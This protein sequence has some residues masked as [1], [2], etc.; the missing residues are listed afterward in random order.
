MDLVPS[1][2]Y[3]LPEISSVGLTER[4]LLA[5]Q[6]PYEVG[7]TNFKSLA[8]AQMT[9]Q[10]IGMLKLLFHTRTLQLLGVHCFGDGAAEIVHIG[11][12]VMA[13]NDLNNLRYFT[14]ATFNYPTMAEA[15]RVAAYNGLN[16]LT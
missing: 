1:G 11:Q 3:T 15:Y 4:D 8:R 16:R 10:T 6:I 7:H 2:I 5:K 9:G 12:T 14:T 13:S